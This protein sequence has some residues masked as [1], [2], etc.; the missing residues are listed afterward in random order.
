M[1]TLEAR[2]ATARPERYLR[3]FA[4]HATAMGSGGGHRIRRHDGSPIAHEDVR[5][6]VEATESHV[7]VR[8]TPWGNCCLHAE[9]GLLRV[10][11]E[12][13]DST[14][15]QRIRDTVTRDIERFGRGE[16]T[17]RWHPADHPGTTPKI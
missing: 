3:Q 8:F 11:I 6:R 13:V 16:F 14:A 5:V 4:K 7:T 1:H 9:P 2:I 17:V 12:A 10:R 15:L